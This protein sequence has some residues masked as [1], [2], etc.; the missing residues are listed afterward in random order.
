MSKNEFSSS[1]SSEISRLSNLKILH[2]AELSLTGQIP[3][4]A[5]KQLTSLE[6]IVITYATKMKGPL[7]ELSEHWPNLNVV[8]IYMSGFDGSIPTTIGQNTN[9]EMLWV[10]AVPMD[11]STI[12][13]EIGLLKNLRGFVF[14]PSRNGVGGATIPTEIGECTNLDTVDW[15]NLSGFIPTEIGKLTKLKEVIFEDGTLSGSIPSEIG[16]L[17]KLTFLGIL[18]NQLK[19]TLP[20]ELGNLSNLEVLEVYA[21]NLTGNVP[22]GVCETNLDIFIDRD[23]SIEECECCDKCRGDKRY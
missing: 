10:D 23:C 21:N 12:P 7:L 8:D 5:M 1:L 22:S 9:L 2:L 14:R 15:N 13:T 6:Q 11:A 18:G 4:D 3:V 20:S 16:L 19:G 17:S